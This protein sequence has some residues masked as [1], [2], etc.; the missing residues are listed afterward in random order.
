MI[1][2]IF[3]HVL[4]LA[5]SPQATPTPTPTSTPTTQQDLAREA[6]AAYDRADYETF[7]EETSRAA[8][9][10]PGDVWVLYNLAC[11]QAI[12]GR[13]GEAVKTLDT[14]AARRVRFDLDAEKDFASI[15]GSAGYRKVSE[16]MKKLG[17]TRIS[18]SAVAFRVPQKGLVPEGVAFDSKT[19]AFFVGSIRKRKIVRVAPDGTSSDFV[20][21]GR[22]GL[23]GALGMRVDA[24]RRRLWVCT[25]AMPHMEGFDKEKAPDSALVAFDADSGK[26]VREYP[27]PRNPE[28]YQP[29]SACDDLTL[30]PDGSVLVNDTEHTRVFV[31][32]PDGEDLEVLVDVPELGRPQGIAVSDDGR[33][34]YV[35]NYRRVMAVDMASRR[36]REVR[37]PADVPL[38]G[39]DGLAFDRGTLLA[40]QNGIEPHRVVRLTLSADGARIVKGRILEMNNPLFDEPTL[41]VAANGAF[42]YVADSQG[43]K[44]LKSPDG[45]PESEQRE[46]VVLK[47]PLEAPGEPRRRSARPG[48]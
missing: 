47:V 45:V 21:S 38:N 10:S 31:L 22:D 46:V 1:A 25:R 26:L 29:P 8:K 28:A 23:R 35:S 19:G 44:F 27:L 37:A 48:R 24:A 18:E 4:A 16:H 15:R 20:A 39:I 42:Y 33:T 3:V 30:A 17:D 36:V 9:M 12:T 43:G 2:A 40:V 32:R 41:G 11:G 14:I 6:R 34:A 7:L 5:A 13:R